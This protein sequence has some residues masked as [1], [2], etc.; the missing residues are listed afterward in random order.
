MSSLTLTLSSKNRK[1]K[2]NQK[3]NETENKKIRKS[4]LLVILTLEEC[5]K[6]WR[7]KQG[8]LGW[9]KQKKEEAKEEAGK[10]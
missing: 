2:I 1:I 8:K 7:P 6:Q 9:Q 5:E 4:P 3:E 10:K